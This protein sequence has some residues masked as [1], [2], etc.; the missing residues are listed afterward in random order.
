MSRRPSP[1]LAL[2]LELAAPAQIVKAGAI[3]CPATPDAMEVVGFKD[4]WV[5]AFSESE[6]LKTDKHTGRA[7]ALDERLVRF[8]ELF[9]L[10]L[11]YHHKDERESEAYYFERPEY[12]MMLIVRYVKNLRVWQGG[13]WYWG[14]ALPGPI[15][16]AD[17]RELWERLDVAWCLRFGRNLGAA[18]GAR[19]PSVCAWEPSYPLC[20]W[21]PDERR[22]A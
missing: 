14:D 21:Q 15:L 1:Q 17:Q 6:A 3:Y 5:A 13:G 12:E 9:P 4:R 22:T 19:L 7:V 18:L 11:V 16:A 20:G 10:A 8:R 2:P